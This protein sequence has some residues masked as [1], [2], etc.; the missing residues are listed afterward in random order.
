VREHYNPALSDAEVEQLDWA[1]WLVLMTG[2]AL[3]GAINPNTAA[4][5]VGVGSRTSNQLHWWLDVESDVDR[6]EAQDATG[7]LWAECGGR[8]E[9][10]AV[11]HVGVSPLLTEWDHELRLVFLRRSNDDEAAGSEITD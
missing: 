6:E 1:N 7:Q 4:V 2:Q 5:A 10:E 11:V 9:F 8:V 3:F